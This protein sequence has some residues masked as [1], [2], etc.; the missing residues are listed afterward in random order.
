MRHRDG[1]ATGMTAGLIAAGVMPA[2]RL[3]AH[4]AGLATSVPLLR[5]VG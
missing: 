3:L 1:I 2:V 4:R 5:R